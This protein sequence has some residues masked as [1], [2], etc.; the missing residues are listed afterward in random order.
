MTPIPQI[1][2][3]LAFQSSEEN[4]FLTRLR[5]NALRFKP[6]EEIYSG[7]DKCLNAK[8]GFVNF[9]VYINHFRLEYLCFRREV[10]K[11]KQVDTSS[12]YPSC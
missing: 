11:R 10:S 4:A 6:Q 8:T 7:G 2:T 5:Q 1:T 3:Y 12:I 9:E